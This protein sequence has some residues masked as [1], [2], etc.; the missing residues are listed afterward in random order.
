MALIDH[1]GRRAN[2]R[3]RRQDVHAL[4]VGSHA[5]NSKRG[6]GSIFKQ[7]SSIQVIWPTSGRAWDW[8]HQQGVMF[9]P[10]CVFYISEELYQSNK[11]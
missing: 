7:A 8:N 9:E 6:R 3:D 4:D 1:G 10:T 5:S 2:R 11:E